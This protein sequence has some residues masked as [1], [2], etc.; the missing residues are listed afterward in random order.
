MGLIWHS[1]IFHF[2]QSCQPDLF[3]LSGP[4]SPIFSPEK[5]SFFASPRF[6]TLKIGHQRPFSSLFG[7]NAPTPHQK[8]TLKRLPPTPPPRSRVP[9]P[10][11]KTRG[12]K[13]CIPLSVIPFLARYYLAQTLGVF[14]PLFPFSPSFTFSIS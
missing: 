2:G 11:S 8:I 9:Q 14:S 12:A 13:W 3:C 6:R 5:I 1:V 7:G 10:H 4:R